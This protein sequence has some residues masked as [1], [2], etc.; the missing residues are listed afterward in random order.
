MASHGVR[1]G[2]EAGDVDDAVGDA[3]AHVV[4]VEDAERWRR[5]ARFLLADQ[6]D[7]DGAVGGVERGGGL[8]EQQDRVVGDEAA[9]DVDALLLAAGEGGGRQR[10]QPLAAG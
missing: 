7:D 10:P 5:P 4:V 2:G 8:V 9:G 6:L 3:V 1:R